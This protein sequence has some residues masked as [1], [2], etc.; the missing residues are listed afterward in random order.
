MALLQD[1]LSQLTELGFGHST[2][3]GGSQL[4]F[5]GISGITPQDIS[6][7]LASYWGLESSD[8]PSGLFSGISEDMLQGAL[9]KTYSP[10]VEAGGSTLLSQL[11]QTMGGAQ[12][13]S[14]YGGF[15]G[16]GQQQKFVGG[17]KDVYGKGA[18]DIL[19]DVYGKQTKGL[20]SIQDVVSEWNKAAQRVKGYNV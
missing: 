18:S 14:A 4:D 12:G 8:V 15:A 17:A 5:M 6:G 16:S 7:R 3:E 1:I 13:K 11:Q 2:P 20:Q 19:A 10:Q 9:G